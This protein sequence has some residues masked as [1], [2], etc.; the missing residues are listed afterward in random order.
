MS[1]G[2]YYVLLSAAAVG[3]WSVLFERASRH[4]APLFGPA[5]AE[6]TGAV[7]AIVFILTRLG[8]GTGGLEIDSTGVRLLLLAG[9]FTFSVD[10]FALQAYSRGLPVS[11]GA[12]ILIGGGILVATV[13][14][15]LLGETA[16]LQKIAGIALVLAGAVTLAGASA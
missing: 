14:G 11:V 12:P 7:I 2:F 16:S 8:A 3:G 1:S 15:F 4:A 13:L 9:V 10:Y 6:L 5:I